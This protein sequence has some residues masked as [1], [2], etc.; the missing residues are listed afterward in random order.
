MVA[1]IHEK[2]GMREDIVIKIEELYGLFFV[3]VF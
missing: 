1:C 2:F 3:F